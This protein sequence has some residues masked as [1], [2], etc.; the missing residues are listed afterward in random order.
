MS[1]TAK[2]QR[3]VTTDKLPHTVF[4]QQ[5]KRIGSVCSSLMSVLNTKK[6]RKRPRKLY[7]PM[8]DERGY[9]HTSA[10]DTKSSS[11]KRRKKDNNRRK[12]EAER[13]T[14]E[15]KNHFFDSV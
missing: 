7:S 15:K 5:E 4:G 8:D 6:V 13:R 3:S 9:K 2:T 14:D 11:G 1:L 12:K 10:F